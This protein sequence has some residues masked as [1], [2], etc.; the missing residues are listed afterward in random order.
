MSTSQPSKTIT[1]ISRSTPYG[2]GL[3]KACLDMVLCA[4]VFDQHINL[5]FMDDG[6]WQLQPHQTPQDINA[7]DLSAALSALPLYEVSNIYAES[8]ALTTRGLAAEQLIIEV[9]PCSAEQIATLIRQSDVVYQ[10]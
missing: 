6:V 4:A 5:V 7:K 1:F 3:A 2:S 9:T 8:E 10:L